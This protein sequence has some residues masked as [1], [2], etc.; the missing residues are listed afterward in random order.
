MSKIRRRTVSSLFVYYRRSHETID[1]FDGTID[2]HTLRKN[3]RCFRIRAQ[4]RF[5]VMGIGFSHAVSARVLGGWATSN[6][7]F[8]NS[9]DSAVPTRQ[10]IARIGILIFMSSQNTARTVFDV[11]TR[12]TSEWTG[13]G[14][15]EV[16]DNGNYRCP[17]FF[18]KKKTERHAVFWLRYRYLRVFFLIPVEAINSRIANGKRVGRRCIRACMEGK[19]QG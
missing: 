10:I 2:C 17:D 12:R 14:G 5:G 15:G 1:K 19:N 4:R 11:L 8:R 3:S 7:P 16:E 9:V 18:G 6:T 13:G